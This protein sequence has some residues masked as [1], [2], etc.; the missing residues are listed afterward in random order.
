MNIAN[1]AGRALIHKYIN[2]LLIFCQCFTGYLFAESLS[3]G[4]CHQK[5]IDFLIFTIM[6]L[7]VKGVFM[8]IIVLFHCFLPP[9]GDSHVSQQRATS[10]KTMDH[11]YKDFL[12]EQNKTFG[13]V[14][15]LQPETVTNIQ[16]TSSDSKS[17]QS[18]S[19][20][21]SESGLPEYQHKCTKSDIV[22]Q[23]QPQ[24]KSIQPV[25]ITV[26]Q[27]VGKLNSAFVQGHNGP[28]ALSGRIK[29]VSDEEIKSNRETEEAIRNIPRFKNYQRGKPSKV[30]CV[31]NISPR[32]SL[33]QLVSLFSRFQKDESQPILYRLLTGRLKGQAF[34]TLADAEIAQAA[35]DLLN[36][37]K[38]LEK[39]LVIEFGRARSKETDLQTDETSVDPNTLSVQN[40]KHT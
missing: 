26:S 27:S 25:K 36:G 8:Y 9:D 4:I 31:K 29:E 39:P 12:E 22:N 24:E 16:C 30:L 7:L 18:Q 1:A 38:L 28:V 2:K 19:P 10:P 11:F 32:A 13:D 37:Y 35:L 34:I 3:K 21:V 33:A 17:D 14:S 15:T 5:N 40:N 23:P 20:T 6:P